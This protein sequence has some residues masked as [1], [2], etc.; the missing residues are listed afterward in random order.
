MEDIVASVVRQEH[1]EAP[2]LGT[3][4]GLLAGAAAAFGFLLLADTYLPE[5]AAYASLLEP[6]GPPLRVLLVFGVAAEGFATAALL[7]R[8][9]E[10]PYPVLAQ[11]MAT[12]LAAAGVILLA[13][14]TLL[15]VLYGLLIGKYWPDL[16][17]IAQVGLVV[18]LVGAGVFLA[19]LAPAACSILR[20]ADGK[21]VD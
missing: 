1:A 17:L 14:G 8:H 21:S 10:A 11:G 9:E 20:F 4:R 13:A 6:L 16:I 15:T 19:A 18:L 7:Y 5:Y 2:R 12:T 3:M